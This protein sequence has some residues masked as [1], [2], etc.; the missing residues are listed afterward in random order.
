MDNHFFLPQDGHTETHV[1]I[2]SGGKLENSS[3]FYRF[4][5]LLL[6]FSFLFHCP[7]HV[8]LLPEMTF[9]NKLPL[10]KQ[11]SQVLLSWE[12]KDNGSTF[13]IYLESDYFASPPPVPP[14][15]KLLS[16][17]ALTAAIVYFLTGSQLLF[18]PS[19]QSI[20]GRATSVEVPTR[21]TRICP[22]FFSNLTSY[23]QLFIL[24]E[25]MTPFFPSRTAD[26]LL[27]QGSCLLFLSRTLIHFIAYLS[28]F[29]KMTCAM[30]KFCDLLSNNHF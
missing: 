25:Q 13:K 23:L 14:T 16:I 29:S 17:L 1:I 5:L 26:A 28:P 11:L 7:G 18:L 27:S 8:P 3:S 22:P 15:S 9:S 20:L 30:K 21:A 12:T 4:F 6:L 24:A 10:F 2:S 19:I